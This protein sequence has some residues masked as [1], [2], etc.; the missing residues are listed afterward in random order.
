L[1]GNFI[2][3]VKPFTSEFLTKNVL[4]LIFK[5][6]TLIETKRLD[7]KSPPE[8]LYKYGRGCDYF[9]LILSGEATIEVGSEKLEFPAGPFAYFGVNALLAGS[10]TADE[11]LQE[12]SKLKENEKKNVFFNG[13]RQSKKYYVPDF[14]LRVDDRCVYMKLG[15]QGGQ[16]KSFGKEISI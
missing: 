3:A 9:I 16:G 13:S 14:S 12:E 4:E 6:C 7:R 8:Y 11:V 5:R 15:K 2:L 1:I 10:E